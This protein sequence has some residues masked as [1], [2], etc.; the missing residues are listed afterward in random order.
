MEIGVNFSIEICAHL[1]GDKFGSFRFLH[2]FL[3][4]SKIFIKDEVLGFLTLIIFEVSI[5]FL[6]NIG[7]FLQ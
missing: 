7:F 6:F 4:W 2:R 1:L 3:H 5:T